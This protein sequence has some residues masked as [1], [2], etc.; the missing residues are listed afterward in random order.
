MSFPVQFLAQFHV[1]E[2]L[3]IVRNGKIAIRADHRLSAI[4]QSDNREP[5]MGEPDIAID[6]NTISIGSAMVQMVEHETQIGSAGF[7]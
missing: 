7:T 5:R 6:Q 1:V 4:C 2:H 3:S